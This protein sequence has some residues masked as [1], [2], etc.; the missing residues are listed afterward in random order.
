MSLCTVLDA[1]VCCDSCSQAVK[2]EDDVVAVAAGFQL[3]VLLVLFM[4]LI[5]GSDR[6]QFGSV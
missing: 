5:E 2:V 1:P 3:Q 6:P 4:S